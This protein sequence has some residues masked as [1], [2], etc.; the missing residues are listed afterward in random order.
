M[1]IK[2][3]GVG[4]LTSAIFIGWAFTALLPGRL[5]EVA[6]PV[7]IG[8]R[9]GISKTAAFATVVLERLFDLLS[10]LVVLVVYLLFFPLPSALDGD[11]AAIIAGMRVSGVA[12][13]GGLVVVVSFLAGAQLFPKRTDAVLR[14]VMDLAPRTPRR[15]L[16]AVRAELS[17]RFAGIRNPKL[18]GAIT[19][20]SALLWSNIVF[21]YYVLFLPSISAAALCGDATRR[22]CGHRGDGADA[23][24]VG[25][26][27]LATELALVGLWGVSTE[28]GRRLRDRFSRHGVRAGHRDRTR[29]AEPRRSV[30]E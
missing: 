19:V 23:A 3:V 14:R 11:G 12:V 15:S 7:L 30:D 10:V 13:L 18:L 6:R 9:E 2:T 17:F 5:G 29:V 26:F 28:Q 27:H 8:R 24:A 4:S 16:A 22:H 20:H 21:T 1:P 25:S